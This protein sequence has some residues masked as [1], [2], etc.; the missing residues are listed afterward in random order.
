MTLDPLIAATL[1]VFF[2]ALFGTAVLHKIAHF[3]IFAMTLG[4]YLKGSLLAGSGAVAAIGG[5]VVAVELALVA[6]WAVPSASV[7]AGGATAAALLGYAVA[8]YVNLRRGNI[9]LDCG[10]SWSYRRQPVSR[11]L[12]L[13]NLCLAA[14]ALAGTLPVVT[15]PLTAIDIVSIAAASGIAA[16]VYSGVNLLLAVAA[17]HQEAR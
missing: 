13:R 12:V 3:R 5:I 15:R 4:K 1:R 8:M 16:M 6:A 17:G 7:I 2:G 11:T 14:L 9:L 10:C